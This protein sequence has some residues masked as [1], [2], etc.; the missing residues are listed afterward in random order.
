MGSWHKNDERAMLNRIRY[1]SL[2]ESSDV[3]GGSSVA[4]LTYLRCIL[5]S[6]NQIDL[7]QLILQY[8]L[9]LPDPP[10][11][12]LPTLRPT[13]I[14]RRRKSETLITNLAK[15]EAK[16][17]P[18]LFT[19]VDLLLSSL[20][21]HNQQTV[22][23]SLRLYSVILHSQHRYAISTLIK[24]QPLDVMNSPRTLDAHNLGVDIILSMAEDLAIEEDLE[25]SYETHM[26]DVHHLLE[27]HSCS[28]Q[29]LAL[30]DFSQISDQMKSETHNSLRS[31]Q[32]GPH[33][34][35]IDD[36]LLNGLVL[37]LNQFLY[38]D[39]ETN[40]SLTQTFTILASCGYTRLEGWL[41]G[42]SADDGSGSDHDMSSEDGFD[43][44]SMATNGNQTAESRSLKI[45]QPPS[46]RHSP[47]TSPV[48]AAI[49]SLIGQIDN[50]RQKIPNFDTY[51]VERKHI[52]RISDEID[53][54]LADPS[55]SRQKSE[56]PKSH[57]SI[58]PSP[59][60]QAHLLG[61]MSQR[62]LF[63]GSP[64]SNVSRSSSP[65]GRQQDESAVS[66][67]APRFNQLRISP[68]R[69][70][71][72][73]GVRAYSS[74][75]LR[76]RT[77]PISTPSTPMGPPDVLL[78]KVRMPITRHATLPGT[79]ET[80]W[81]PL[82]NGSSET[83]SLRSVDS[84]D[85]RGNEAEVREVTLGHLLTNVVILQEFVLELAA[86]VEVRAGLFVDEIKF[87]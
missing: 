14:A 73:L 18:N 5:E 71:S 24:V 37:L 21:S 20:Q 85:V 74:S 31:K 62:L 76:N 60:T 15:G 26:L 57:S 47:S 54:A 59:Q 51:L 82:R 45:A 81:T 30:P 28:A 7:I 17:S 55:L 1:P 84:T 87:V 75:P 16:P 66:K 78:Q 11:E 10:P 44:A 48:F 68:S 42:V 61:S 72:K 2:V 36:P 39:I 50:F 46:A 65:R 56:D 19:L 79:F 41:L 13:T 9:A 3:D 64:S 12:K 58:V 29:I 4:V 80:P 23:A 86:V 34:I 27:A 25:A 38:N 52:F 35:A 32:V 70:P 49:Y 33:R 8:L 67:L 43:E 6:I 40:L 83:T 63:D 69:S 22:T 77:P 53:S